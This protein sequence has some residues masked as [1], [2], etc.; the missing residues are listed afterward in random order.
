MFCVQYP[1]FP[2]NRAVYIDNVESC[3]RAGQATDDN[4]AHS[5]CMLG[6]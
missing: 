4:M 2:K 3:C 6:T 1:F 5:H